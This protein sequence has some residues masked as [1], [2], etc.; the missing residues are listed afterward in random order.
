[1]AEP[2]TTATQTVHSIILGSVMPEIGSFLLIGDGTDDQTEL[3]MLDNYNAGTDTWTIVRGVFDTVPKAW[4]V[5][6][7]IWYIPLSDVP[8]D[9]TERLAG[10]VVEYKLQSRTSQGLL[11]LEETP[12]ET[13]EL[14]ARPYL[15]FRP[16]NVVIGGVSGLGS[17][18]YST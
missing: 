16:A 1:A 4:P 14:S 12:M 17:L 6:T 5:G 13:F 2:T 11:P 15:P 10:E 9:L 8:M 3:A 18:F 7:P